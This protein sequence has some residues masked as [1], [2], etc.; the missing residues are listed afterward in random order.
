M[1]VLPVYAMTYLQKIDDVN[2]KDEEYLPK[3]SDFKDWL[4]VQHG[5]DVVYDT[6][7]QHELWQY[8]LDKQDAFVALA[9]A[10]PILAKPLFGMMNEALTAL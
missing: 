3:R 8:V 7:S 2:N 4:W 6:C 5:H 1:T 10:L 9:D